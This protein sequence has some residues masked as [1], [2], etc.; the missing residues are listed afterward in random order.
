MSAIAPQDRRV[1]RSRVNFLLSLAPVNAKFGS[2]PVI[3]STQS[4][5]DDYLSGPEFASY[6]S[7]CAVSRARRDGRK[8]RRVLFRQFADHARYDG[9]SGPVDVDVFI[10]SESDFAALTHAR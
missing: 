3:Y 5:F 6:P 9:L 4:F 10:G 2:A 7:G 8:G 1:R